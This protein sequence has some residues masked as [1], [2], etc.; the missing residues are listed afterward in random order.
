VQADVAFNGSIPFFTEYDCPD[1][2]ARAGGGAAPRHGIV[3]SA[4]LRL[5]K[6][7]QA[8]GQ[9]GAG[10]TS[11]ASR[12]KCRKMCGQSSIIPN[13]SCDF[14]A[15][16]LLLKIN[17]K[18]GARPSGNPSGGKAIGRVEEF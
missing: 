8:F 9:T 2:I 12:P 17:A 4:I 18:R 14:I 1:M 13:I 15:T 7:H 3:N 6:D 16:Q 11:Q 5:R 10:P